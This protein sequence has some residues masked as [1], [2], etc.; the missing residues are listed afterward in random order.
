MMQLVKMELM[1]D[2]LK[3]MIEG[4]KMDREKGSVMGKMKMM[5]MME[6]CPT[7]LFDWQRSKT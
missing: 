5:E 7:I 6:M 3:V 1:L 4:L 2:Q